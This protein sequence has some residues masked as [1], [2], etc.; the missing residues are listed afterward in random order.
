M[1]AFR[2]HV[3]VSTMLGLGYGLGAVVGFG[4]SPV[5]GILACCATGIAGML[6]DLDSPN[7]R[8]IREMFGFLGAVMPLLMVDRVINWLGLPSNGETMLLVLGVLYL[9]VK[10]GGAALVDKFSIHRGMYH[11]IP[12]M[13]IAAELMYLGYPNQEQRV[14]V[15]M[16]LGVAIGFFSHLLLDE[17]YSVEMNNLSVRLKK[18]S[19]T[20]I[21]LFGEGFGANVVAFTLLASLTFMSLHDAGWL[22][23]DPEKLLRAGVTT[24]ATDP[25]TLDMGVS[26]G[27]P[28]QP[29]SFDTPQ[30]NGFPRTAPGN[31]QVT[32]PPYQQV[33]PF[34][35]GAPSNSWS[36]PANWSPPNPA[37]TGNQ[38]TP[39]QRG[40]MTQTPPTQQWIPPNQRQQ[41]P[42]SQ[43]RGYT[44]PAPAAQSNAP[45]RTK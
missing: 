16:A 9:A 19:G 37:A 8:P 2:E 27:T 12:A 7:G 36:P 11:S 42:L 38:W 24:P 26:L 43:P 29:N 1:A 10:Y 13:L 18:S 20:A 31:T 14:K 6:P 45:W 39:P 22:E 30:T 44:P 5:Q 21:K 17:I 4:F 15:M 40:S 34:N 23:Q 41:Q 33:P 3:S 32:S 35:Q 25:D 28:S